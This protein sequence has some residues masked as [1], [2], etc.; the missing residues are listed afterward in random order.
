[1]LGDLRF[2]R[3]FVERPL[4]DL[5]VDVGDVRYMVDS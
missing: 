2:G 3:S 4:D 5:V 1:M